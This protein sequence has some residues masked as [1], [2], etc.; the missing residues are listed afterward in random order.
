[1]HI[2]SY[3]IHRGREVWNISVTSNSFMRRGYEKWQELLQFEINSCVVFYI[4]DLRGLAFSVAALKRTN[5][6]FMRHLICC[7]DI[8][9]LWDIYHNSC[10]C[11]CPARTL[12]SIIVTVTE[13]LCN[14]LLQSMS[15]TVLFLAK[16]IATQPHPKMLTGG[17]WWEKISLANPRSPPSGTESTFSH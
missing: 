1:M 15:S 3:L 7:V 2:C 17:A 6:L 8:C 5:L 12:I 16:L 13:W 14:K 4:P 9:E 10:V 11:V